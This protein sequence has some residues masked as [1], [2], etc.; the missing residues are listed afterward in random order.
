[1]N[2]PGKLIAVTATAAIRRAVHKKSECEYGKDFAL[3]FS[4]PLDNELGQPAVI[5]TMNLK[6]LV[7]ISKLMV[8]GRITDELTNTRKGN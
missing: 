5:L 6:A 8:K 4:R 7:Y 2:N 1:M 3:D